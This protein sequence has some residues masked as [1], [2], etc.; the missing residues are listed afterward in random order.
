MT[1]R[2]WRVLIGSRS[3]GKRI[4]EHI[5]QLKQAGCEVIPNSVG[6]AYRAEELLEILPGMD[7]IITGTDELT[8]EVIDAAVSLR[9]IAKHG[10]GLET[11]DLDAAQ[12]RGIV[13]SA[14]PGTNHHSVADLTM[15]LLLA[16]ARGVVRSHNDVCQG[17]WQAVYGMELQDKKMG[18]VGLGRIGKQVCLRARSFGMTVLAFDP[19]PDS[20]WAAE[21]GVT[22]ASL[23]EL[24]AQADVV[25]LHAAVEMIDGPL[26]GASELDM[27]KPTAILVNTARGA[28]VDEEALVTALQEGQIAGAGLDAFVTEPPVDSPLLDLNNVVLTAHLGGRTV[29]AQRKQ[30]KMCLENCLRA[31]RGDEPLYRVV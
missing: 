3:F 27:M 19:Y 5:T 11:I 22:F 16:V 28:L 25:S 13:V 7:A 24:I 8:A 20:A 2:K 21:N 10:V 23:A 6:R 29:D 9:T 15:A 31:L 1:E 12:A 14:T 4:P 18:V 17:G 30:G 26:I